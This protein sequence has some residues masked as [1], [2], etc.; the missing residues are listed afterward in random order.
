M[1]III[2]YVMLNYAVL[3]TNESL[4]KYSRWSKVGH[5]AHLLTTIQKLKAKH[6]HEA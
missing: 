4:V 2:Y 1:Y 5:S 3:V 6:V